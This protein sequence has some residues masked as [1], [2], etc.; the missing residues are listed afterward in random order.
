MPRFSPFR[1]LRYDPARFAPEDVTAPPYDVLSAAD[2]A[3]LVA[4]NP[5]NAVLIDLPAEDEGEDRYHAAG[6]R[7][8]AWEAE[9]VVHLDAAPEMTAYRMTTVDDLGNPVA[10][11][12]VLGALTL[13]RP[14]EGEI[15]PH[16]HTTPKAKSDR[17][18]LLRG[19]RANLSAI[20][21]LSLAHGLTD[22]IDIDR[23]PFQ[24]WTQTQGMSGSTS[25]LPLA[26]TPP[27]GPLRSCLGQFIGQDMPV[28]ESAHWPHIWQSKRKPLVAFSTVMVE[29]VL[30]SILSPG[31]TSCVLP[32]Y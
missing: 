24:A 15:L 25:Q 32:T 17:L 12:G 19:T 21:G 26:R 10:T 13:S 5:H 31:M 9:G 11:L 3:A 8:R 28:E 7:L 20:W 16:E 23:E 4:K 18:D 6:R 30:G 1:S 22:L 27:Q 29:V 14:D 2:R